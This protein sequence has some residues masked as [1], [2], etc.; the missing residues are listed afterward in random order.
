MTAVLEHALW[1]GL[2][3]SI[4]LSAAFFGI[5]LLNQEIWLDDLPRDIQEV[6]GPQS[7]KAVRQKWMLGLPVLLVA[8]AG[9]VWAT[10]RMVE[11]AES[12]GFME[13]FLHTFVALSVF[14]LVDLLILDWLIL[15]RIRPD[16][17]VLPGTEGLAGYADYR[18]HANAFLVGTVGILVISL[19]AGAAGLLL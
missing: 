2:A 5:A 10:L 1:T 16:F 15:V 13:L 3:L 8:L 19:L 11:A 14:N 12:V 4:Y 6:W 9:V 17:V 18:F 7:P